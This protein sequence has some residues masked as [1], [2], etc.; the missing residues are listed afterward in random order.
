MD[1]GLQHAL[2]PGPCGLQKSQ[3]AIGIRPLIVTKQE[4]SACLMLSYVY[5]RLQTLNCP[6]AVGHNIC[7]HF[8]LQAASRAAV[9]P[10]A[11]SCHS[12][13]PHLDPLL[14]CHHPGKSIISVPPLQIMLSVSLLA[15]LY[16]TIPDLL[17]WACLAHIGQ[18]TSH[19]LKI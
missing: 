18:G 15:S 8:R 4:Q 7:Q 5:T 1:L 9:I 19:S 12:H 17:K 11:N 13:W 2:T 3:Q 10:T 16:S 14:H 6:A